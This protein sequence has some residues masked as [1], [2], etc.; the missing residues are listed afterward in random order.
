MTITDK[1]RKLLTEE[2]LGECWHEGIVI[3][4]KHTNIFYCSCKAVKTFLGNDLRKH[5]KELNRSFDTDADMM[6][7]FRKLVNSLNF[8]AF[9]NFAYKRFDDP[10]NFTLT[11]WLFYD[12]ERFCCLVAE[13]WKEKS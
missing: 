4:E 10:H 8:G 7:L 12:P 9:Q 11:E 13:W 1:Q 6:A 3:D 5:C 2:M